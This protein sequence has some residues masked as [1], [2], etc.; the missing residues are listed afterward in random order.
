VDFWRLT[1]AA[2]RIAVQR[3]QQVQSAVKNKQAPARATADFSVEPP[4]TAVLA[5]PAL[6]VNAEEWKTRLRRL[7]C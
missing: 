4:R 7:S 3:F 1:D 6:K 5:V 2:Q